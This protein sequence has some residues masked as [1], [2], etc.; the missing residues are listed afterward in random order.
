MENSLENVTG[1][2]LAGGFGTRLQAV[3]K[4]RPKALSEVVG[5]PFLTYLLDKLGDA[6]I[7][8]SPHRRCGLSPS[9]A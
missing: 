8:H 4:D 3:V 2:V 9:S 1:V 5:K 6:G 7:R